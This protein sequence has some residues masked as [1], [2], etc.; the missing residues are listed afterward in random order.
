M[1]FSAFREEAQRFVS[2]HL[3]SEHFVLPNYKQNNI[4]N[5][6]NLIGKIFGVEELAKS[7]LADYFID[8]YSGVEKVVLFVFDGLGFYRLINH[9]EK[10]KSAF[11][12]LA[13]RGVLKPFSSTFPSTTSTAL[14]SI[15]TGLAPSQHGIIG[16]NMFI[17]DYG[18]IFNTLDMRPIHGYSGGIDLAEDFA[19]NAAPWL[20][21]LKNKGI[22]VKTFTRRNLMGSGLSKVIHKH[23]ELI[24][25]A[26]S[27]DLMVQI[28]KILQEPG[29][30]FFCVYYAGFDTLEHA[31]G[32][33]SEETEAELE[34]FENALRHELFEKLPAETKQKTLIIATADHGV[35][36]ALQAHFLDDPEIR[37]RFLLPPTGDM[38]ATYFFPKYS[39][40]QEL[41]KALENNLQG[42]HIINSLDLVE[43]GAFGPPE[44]PDWLKTVVGSVTA[45]SQSKNII[46]YPLHP[47]ER[48]QSVLGAHGGMTP[49]EMIVP[50]LS[51]RLSKL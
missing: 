3:F 8:D 45:L 29:K 14:T 50:L 35:E 11:F 36:E 38:R 16:F 27:S 26:L 33:Y 49:E 7:N 44:N 6:G 30:Q 24:G 2:Q 20:P 32:P 40:E 34:L 1:S 15:F 19:R 43:K 9:M 37:D 48:F 10:H 42:F 39:Q 18:I 46:L 17:P 51:T 4:S 13:D 5:I 41:R 31:Y 23:Q 25:Y 22:K 47:G 21:L 12:D 28:R